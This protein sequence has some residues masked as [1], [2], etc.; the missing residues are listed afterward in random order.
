MDIFKCMPLIFKGHRQNRLPRS[1]MMDLHLLK[2]LIRINSNGMEFVFHYLI[3]W[4]MK[5]NFNVNKHQIDQ[6]NH[7]KHFV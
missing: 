4:C 3:Q 2:I 5:T 6:T 7:N 1:K